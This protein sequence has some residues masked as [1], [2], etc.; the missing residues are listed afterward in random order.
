[1]RRRGAHFAMID[2]CLTSA[3]RIGFVFPRV[4]FDLHS[5]STASDGVLA[6]HELVARAAAR[7]VSALAL[8]DHDTVQGVAE[9]QAAAQVAGIRLVNGV[10]ISVSWLGRTVHIVGLNVDT[11]NAPLLAGLAMVRSGRVARARTMADSLA[12]VGIG[13]AFEGAAVYATNLEMI[14]RTHFARFLVNSGRVGSMP[15]VFKRFLV[16][17]K[18]GYVKHEWAS[19][20]EAVGWIVG[21]GGEAVIAHPGRYDMGRVRMNEL[22][23][24]FRALGGTAIEVV[25]GSHTTGHVPVFADYAAA[26]GLKASTGSDFHAPG[27]GG[28]DFGRLQALPPRCVP[29]WQDWV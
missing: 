28:R 3:N 6:P 7:G 1:M 9:A 4:S 8:T 11:D 17:G 10:E 19:L 23:G 27:E 26:F 25:C 5:H 20:S 22:L 16:P 18:P 21:A 2:D 14:G 24:E 29:I 12:A 15:S 13:A